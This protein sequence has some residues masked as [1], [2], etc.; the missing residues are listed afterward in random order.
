MQKKKKIK[1]FIRITQT[2]I[3]QFLQIQGI[4]PWMQWALS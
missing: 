4:F 2:S 1:N 3:F